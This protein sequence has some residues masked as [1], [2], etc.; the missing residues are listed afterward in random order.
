MPV[1]CTTVSVR[2]LKIL[3]EFRILKS[4]AFGMMFLDRFAS[5]YSILVLFLF[6]FSGI[7]LWT[8]TPRWLPPRPP[9]VSWGHCPVL[10]L[11]AYT[12][13]RATG[14][15]Q[16]FCSVN[17]F[18]FRNSGQFSGIRRLIIFW[19]WL[20]DAGEGPVHTTIGWVMGDPQASPSPSKPGN[21]K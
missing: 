20:S 21:Q 19:K 1:F 10:Y 11:S 12:T 18:L 8:P 3:W 7:S 17:L 16:T 13:E 5:I 9:P 2:C 6:L 15:L 14:A 4:G